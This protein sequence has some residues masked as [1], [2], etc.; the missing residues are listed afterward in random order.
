[1][2][3]REIT[4]H[5]THDV[6]G[7]R[8]TLAGAAPRIPPGAPALALLVVCLPFVYQTVRALPTAF[9]PEA[10]SAQGL[11]GIA[12]MLFWCGLLV[13][14]LRSARRSA[15]WPIGLDVDRVAGEL[16][17][18]EC[19]LFGW[20]KREEVLQLQQ[21]EGLIVR[22]THAAPSLHDPR[23][24][25]A[26]GPGLALSFRIAAQAPGAPSLSRDLT[27]GVEHLDQREEITDLA[28]RI[29]AAAGLAAFKLV[30]SDA[31][32]VEIELR[33]QPEAGFEPLP[34]LLGPADYA[35]DTVAPA[36][37]AASAD[38]RV[39]PF[40]PGGFPSEHRVALWKPGVAVE[41]RKPLSF[42]AIGCLPFTLL[43]LT[44]P[45]LFPFIRA[46]DGTTGT[47]AGRL[48]ITAMLGLLGVLAG[49]AAAAVVAAG[50]PHHVRFDWTSRVIT[51]GALRTRRAIPFGAVN[52]VEL[53][54]VRRV[55]RGK[56]TRQAYFCELGL[57]LRDP[58]TG[59]VTCERLL[60]TERFQDGPETPYRAALPLATELAQALG[61]ERRVLDG[62]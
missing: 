10:E 41:L 35:R 36:A 37:R 42:G 19:G 6:P 17:L 12:L 4:M 16:R 40:E 34:E 9:G 7:A 44:G 54:V 56:H 55:H 25:Q 39:P 47:L 51:L 59:V 27:L 46:A 14:A 33:R 61:V 58:A 13:S 24:P 48:A 26:P 11:A 62:E 22:R 31:R 52:G 23:R 28:L 50:W 2:A 38:E 53:K 18:Q 15:R 3:E 1:M 20:A 45:A 21:V 32:D 60:E 43:A 57:R 8:L 5:I 49:L 30:R 29:G